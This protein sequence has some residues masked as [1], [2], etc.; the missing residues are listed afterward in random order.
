MIPRVRLLLAAYAM[1]QSLSGRI[2]SAQSIDDAMRVSV[3]YAR[4]LMANT[5]PPRRVVFLIYSS[6]S[7]D[8]VTDSL[9]RTMAAAFRN[10]GLP[11]LSK[12][13]EPGPDTVLAS[14]SAAGLD[15]VSAAGRFYSIFSHQSYCSPGAG[16]S[17]LHAIRLRCT[18]KVCQFLTEEATGE[19]M[20]CSPRD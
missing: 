2:A 12:W 14:V 11:F 19:G 5:A 9:T 16:S 6:E 3:W 7:P 10:A 13:R 1:T 15:S 18:A 20:I 4:Q 17:A 8:P